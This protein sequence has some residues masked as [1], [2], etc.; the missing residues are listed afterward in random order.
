MYV[1]RDLEKEIA[2]FLKRKEILAVVGARQAGKTTFLQRLFSELKK[3]KKAEYLT[4]ERENS[5]SLF[6][7]IED[8][9]DYYKEYKTI[10]I[11]EFHYATDGGKK[12]KYLFDTAKTKFIISGSSSLELSFETGKYLVGRMIKFPLYPF[13]FREFLSFKNKKLFAL[14]SLRIGD[15]LSDRFN[16]K[17]SFGREINSQLENYFEEYLIFG[18]YPAVV[19]AKTKKEKI[20]ILESILENYLLKDIKALLNLKSSR[21][22]LKISEFLSAQ[23]GE[24]LNYREL[25][26]VSNLPYKEVIRHLE[27]LENTF[28]VSLL[29][30]FFVNSR[31]ELVKTPKVYFIDTGFRNYLL[32][33]FKEFQKRSDGGRLVENFVFTAL[34]RRNLDKINFWRTKSKAE[35]DFV[36]QKESKIVPIEVKYSTKPKIGKSAYSFIEKFSP[37]RLYIFT[38]GYIGEAKIK[39]CKI[40]FVP[41]YYL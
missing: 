28:I 10:I 24:L 19:L 15:I 40:K 4:F 35:L 31:T 29:R 39:N 16:F 25:S 3:T 26:N 8:F 13:S 20:K 1:H 11:D 34:K 33:D 37:P 22:L 14:L 32:S 30:P 2:P 23:I 6:E 5:L 17:R 36:V 12:L 18:G 21:E 41:A 27:I 9:R 38:R 7:S